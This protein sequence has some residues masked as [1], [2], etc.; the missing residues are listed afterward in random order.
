MN[1]QRIKG[2]ESQKAGAAES[3]AIATH[4]RNALLVGRQVLST[5]GARDVIL[6]GSRARGDYR[7]D[8]DIDLLVILPGLMKFDP[9][10]NGIRGQFERTAHTWAESLYEAP[11]MVQLVWY[12]GEEF[13]RFRR[14]LNHVTAIASREGISM[15]GSPASDQYPDEGDYAEEWNVTLDRC[16]HAR[17]HLQVLRDVVQ[18][19]HPDLVV[20]QQAQQTLEHAIKGLISAV[21]RGYRHIHDLVELE[22]D[23]KR[24]DRQFGYS[25]QSPLELLSL[26]A[27]GD[28]Y[29]H[30]R[31]ENPLGDSNTLL[32]QVEGD[33]Q[34]LFQR[35]AELTGR[36]PWQDQ[37]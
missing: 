17:A 26:Y 34:H 24:A 11:V 12:S 30:G 14:S 6:F 25:L 16:Y 5:T 21:G 32:R 18:L 10:S 22:G 4:D 36:D 9:K 29:R 35:I 13:D 20:G 15:N 23:L 1:A 27:G 37:P 3:R 33:V 7:D 8:S 28:I 2:P 19:G 31:E